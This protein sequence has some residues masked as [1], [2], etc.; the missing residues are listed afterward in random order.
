MLI[1][2]IKNIFWVTS[3]TEYVFKY[4]CMY[5]N[6]YINKTLTCQNLWWF[7]SRFQHYLFYK[8][9]YIISHFKKVIGVVNKF[10]FIKRIKI[11]LIKQLVVFIFIQK[12]FRN[13][14]IYDTK[15]VFQSRIKWLR[16]IHVIIDD[17]CELFSIGQ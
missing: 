14:I 6:K 9:Y 11:Y 10:C 8:K 7:P 15:N 17:E 5:N 1:C 12:F 4:L 13:I 2:L 16:K 3:I